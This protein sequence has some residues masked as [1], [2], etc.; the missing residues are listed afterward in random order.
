MTATVESIDPRTGQVVEVV[1]HEFTP[2]EVD[3]ACTLAAAAGPALE[4][5]GPQGRA[6]MLRLMADELDKDS[7]KIVELADRESAL[8]EPRL[9]GELARSSFQL[10][11]FAS[12]LDDGAY[13]NV[14]IDHA[15]PGA[16][17]VPRPD[18]RRMLVPLG[19]VAVFGASNFPLAFSVPGGDTASAL[20]AGCPVVVKAHPAH[21]ATS[22]RCL[23]ALQRG[24]VGA[25]LP[26]EAITAI[27]G[28]TAGAELVR[29][30]AVRAVG[31]TG[32]V[33]GGRALFDL[34]CARP[35]PIPFYGE[36]GSLN[37]VVVT[38]A[39]AAERADE[40]AAGLY[41]SFTNG[42]GQFCTKPGVVFVPAG[43]DGQRLAV[44][45][46]EA[47]RGYQPDA[48]LAERIR[49]GFRAGSDERAGLVGVSVLAESP[50]PQGGGFFAPARLVSVPA[51]T[52][53][54]G[55]DRATIFDECFGPLTVLV[56]YADDAEL[57]AALAHLPGS[58]TATVHAGADEAPTAAID[59]LLR[60][61]GRFVWNGYPTGVAVTWATQ[62][63]GPYPSSTD[64]R[65]TS[66]GTAAIERWLRPV[67]YQSMPDQLLPEALQEANPWRL[68]RRVD[69]VLQLS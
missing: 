29:H 62:H 34:A 47:T 26:V 12:V 68:P 28:G 23:E 49:D 8:G 48:M 54:D 3:A 2:N 32:S 57:L 9:R 1:A 64:S 17:P 10:R 65:S 52:V 55:N 56:E 6:R 37:P 66:V 58:L 61:A 30:P 44:A 51:R 43:T 27:H 22:Q 24:A 69:G 36:L 25:G 18:L 13:L 45:L 59:L 11:L 40:I 53:L 38:A 4:Q 50:A 19:P 31:F 20:A 35:E 41:T 46:A 21:P 14:T 63:G 33:A 16:T 60:R 5:A 42:V 15:D 7:D 67:A 39:A